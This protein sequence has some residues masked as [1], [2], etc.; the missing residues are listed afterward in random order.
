MKSLRHG[1]RRPTPESWLTM[2]QAV[3]LWEVNQHPERH[4]GINPVAA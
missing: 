1:Q 4:A 2:Q 3:D